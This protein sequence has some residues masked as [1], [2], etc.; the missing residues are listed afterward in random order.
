MGF[1]L[2][3]ADQAT[4]E[5]QR[6]VVKNERRQNYENAPY[7]LVGQ[8]IRTELYPDGHPYRL[9][10]I[11]TPQDLDAARL[12]DVKA[13]F[14]TWYVPNNASLVVAGD[15]DKKKTLELVEKY[16]G[17]IPGAKIPARKAPP[18]VELSGVRT[19]RVS[20]AVE[21]PRITLTWPT[22]AFF[23]PGDAELDLVAHILT[24]GKTSRLYKRLVYDL[25]I[26]QDVSAGQGSMEWCSSFS[27]G[28]TLRAGKSV[29]EAQRIVDEELAKFA[30]EGPTAAELARAKTSITA[31]FVYDIERNGGRANHIN[32][33]NHYTGDPNYIGKDM[34]R[35]GSATE[36]ALRDA[37][38]RYLPLGKRIV[39][40]VTPDKTAPL[41]GRLDKVEGGSK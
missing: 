21:L 27:V 26:A 23:A 39:T 12:D 11:G 29:E 28:I 18:K 32:T 24:S 13:F 22:P 16:F 6:D 2:D 31:S 25:Q 38:A 8:F 5:S 33:Y 3:H 7:G 40:V 1:L 36:T 30:Q 35:Y 17:P 9:Q 20:A 14:R 4:F 34:M 19:M 10:T 41:A 15:I 37:A